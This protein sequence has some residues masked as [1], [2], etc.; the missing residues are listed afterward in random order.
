MTASLARSQLIVYAT[1]GGG[2]GEACGRFWN[3]AQASGIATSAQSYPPHCSLTGFFKSSG[4]LVSDVE[5]LLRAEVES[6]GTDGDHRE[7][8]LERRKTESWLGLSIHC[9]NWARLSQK[10]ADECESLPIE[11]VRS[12]SDLHLSPAY[13]AGLSADEHLS[14]ALGAFHGVDLWD[15]SWTIGLWAFERPRW[16]QLWAAEW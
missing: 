4:E 11:P 2:I 10:F 14:L 9:S 13:G 5:A 15:V 1:P 6:L 8:V 12:K 7:V 16:R 3:Q